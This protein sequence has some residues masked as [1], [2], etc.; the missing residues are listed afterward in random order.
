MLCT[1]HI[2]IHSSDGF[3]HF[4]MTKGHFLIEVS[5]KS[6]LKFHLGQFA[7]DVDIVPVGSESQY[8]MFEA[9]T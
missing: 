7:K 4:V 6:L 8:E 2:F 1:F 5:V 9:L 3:I